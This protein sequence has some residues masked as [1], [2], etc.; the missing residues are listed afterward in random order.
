M[1]QFQEPII[2]RRK[3]R[4]DTAGL[5]VR[6]GVGRGNGVKRSADPSLLSNRNA[7]LAGQMNGPPPVSPGNATMVDSSY[8]LRPGP[9]QV[10]E[11]QKPQC[12][13]DDALTPATGSRN[14]HG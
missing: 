8:G 13:S 7:V 4:G 14:R 11:K 9:S 12:K 5:R 6:E 1:I 10:G 3:P 2:V